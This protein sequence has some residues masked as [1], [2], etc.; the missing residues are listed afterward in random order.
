MEVVE[1]RVE[2]GVMRFARRKVK[3]AVGEDVSLLFWFFWK[4]GVKVRD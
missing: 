2:G 3:N 1:F 4:R